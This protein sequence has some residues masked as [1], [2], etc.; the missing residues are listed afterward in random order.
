M[1]I[2]EYFRRIGFV[3]AAAA[4]LATFRAVHR[5][6]A[7]SLVYENLDVQLGVPVTR[8]AAAA[9]DKIVRRGRGG[10]CYEMNGLLGSALQEIGFNVTFLAGGVMR[11]QMGDGVVGNHLVL[12]V[13]IGGDDWIGDVGFGDGLIDPAPL[14]EGPTDGN[15][16]DSHFRSIG[17]GWWRFANDPKTG[18]P[19]FDFNPAVADEALLEK[20][21]RF[22]RSDPA[23]PFVQ[24]AV[25]QRWTDGAHLS[26][27]GRVL[28]R[29]TASV[30]RKTMIASAGEYVGALKDLF[31]IDVP[32]A[33]R[34]WPRICAR[35]DDLFGDEDPTS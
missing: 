17:G 32:Q 35:H 1:P 2:D 19:T 13:R 22:L 30:D 31:E 4:D 27:R 20:N 16:L 25:V 7:L 26:L 12:L 5:A 21:C 10:W 11:D 9:F 29:L 15:P 23:S 14:R 3:G 18:G 33:A 34:L 6:H 24:N 28:R 8:D